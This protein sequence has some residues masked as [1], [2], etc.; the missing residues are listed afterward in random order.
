MWKKIAK[1]DRDRIKTNKK[2]GKKG[3]KKGI[4]RGKKKQKENVQIEKGNK[5]PNRKGI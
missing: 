2:G 5:S 1:C 4:E 3:E